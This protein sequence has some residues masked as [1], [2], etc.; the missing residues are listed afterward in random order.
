MHLVVLEQFKS[1]AINNVIEKLN[2]G[3]REPIKVCL[4]EKDFKLSLAING[5]Q[6]Q[7][8]ILK[9][10]GPKVKTNG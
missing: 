6:K 8:C 3:Q 2:E 10:Q 1:N 4:W 7:G 5:I 9:P